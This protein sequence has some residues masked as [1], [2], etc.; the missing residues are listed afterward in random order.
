MNA[1]NLVDNAW[2]QVSYRTKNSALKKKQ[3]PDR[4]LDGFEADSGSARHSRKIVDDSTI[5]DDIVT[6]GQSMG[7]E[8]DADDIDQLLEDHSIELTTEELKHLQ[9][10]KEFFLP[11]TLKKKKTMKT[12]KKM[13]QL[14]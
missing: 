2:N 4:D 12:I 1:I 14:L 6:T 10:E 11:I 13:S 9:N 5:I 7:L 8:I 3:W